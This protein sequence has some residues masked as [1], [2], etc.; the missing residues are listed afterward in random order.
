MPF[1]PRIARAISTLAGGPEV[2]DRAERLHYPDAGHGY[3]QFGMHPDF[4]ALAKAC[5]CHGARP[6][7]PDQLRAALT[8][9]FQADAPTVIVVEEKAPWLQ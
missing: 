9:A 1:R 3:D 2:R 4:V 5:R 7:G 6:Q 8:G